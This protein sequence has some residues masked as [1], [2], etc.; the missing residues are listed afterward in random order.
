MA[1]ELTFSQ[2]SLLVAA[3]PDGIDVVLNGMR[4][5]DYVEDSMDIMAKKKNTKRIL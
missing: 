3:Q 1:S 2:K 5:K 4:V